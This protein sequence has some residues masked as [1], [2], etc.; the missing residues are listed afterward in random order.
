MAAAPSLG[1]PVYGRDKPYGYVLRTSALSALSARLISRHDPSAALSAET[2]VAKRFR[3]KEVVRSSSA[4]P[5]GGGGPRGEGQ[6]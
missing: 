1:V 2:A 4:G 5:T 6:L 3:T